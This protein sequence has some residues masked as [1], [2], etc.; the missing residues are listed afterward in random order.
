MIG[1]KKSREV[2]ENGHGES[3]E[4][5]T[6]SELPARS[7]GPWDASE[8][9]DQSDERLDLGALRIQ[10]F[11]GLN[12][13][14]Q[15]DESTGAVSL[16]TLVDGDASLQVQAFAA[17]KSTGTWADIRAQLSASI[18]GSGG[19]VEEVDG[20]FGTELRA[21]VPGAGGALQPARFVGVDGPRWFL[22]GL[23]FG[24]AAEPGGSPRLET[25][26]RDI[27]VVR[28]PD[29]LPVGEPLP[30]RMPQ[31]PADD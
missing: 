12:M 19:L 31:G 18:S 20:E 23:F 15:M 25:L 6:L 14:V 4:E 29:A 24:S 16:V 10:G 5:L 26:F 11:D 7:T 21:R 27:V 28:S 3:A 13:Q 22:R 2:P 9:S 17:P 8:V 1:R 30:M